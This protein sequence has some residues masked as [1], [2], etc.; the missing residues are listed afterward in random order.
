MREFPQKNI[1]S[2]TMDSTRQQKYA[3]LIQKEIGEIFQRD[4]YN[5]YGNS[6]VEGSSTNR[7]VVAI[8]IQIFSYM[9]CV[10]FP[11]GRIVGNVILYPFESTAVTDPA[12]PDPRVPV[13]E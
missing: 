3:R 9:K 8:T 13:P 5:F 6:V 12:I 7:V 4:G 10:L 11:I 1:P 2:R